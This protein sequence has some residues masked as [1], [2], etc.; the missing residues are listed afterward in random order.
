MKR[1]KGVHVQYRQIFKKYFPLQLAES[2][3]MELLD[4]KGQLRQLYVHRPHPLSRRDPLHQY[5]EFG[6]D[7][8]LL[9]PS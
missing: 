2:K 8:F 3:N 7:L 5:S 9:V 6:L 1:I 4:E